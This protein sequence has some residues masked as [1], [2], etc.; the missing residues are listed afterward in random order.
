[1]G[2]QD[3]IDELNKMRERDKITDVIAPE[4]VKRGKDH[5]NKMKNEERILIEQM[6]SHCN[7]FKGNFKDTAK[8]DWVD[9]AMT[10]FDNINKRLEAIIN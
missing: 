9:S 8:G 3:Q 1:M 2:F 10:E 4:H 7:S 6:I 5:E